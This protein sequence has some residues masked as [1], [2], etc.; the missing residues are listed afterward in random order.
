MTRLIIR[1]ALVLLVSGQA[2][3]AANRHVDIIN[4]TG[5]TLSEFYASN[6][7]ANDWEEDILGRQT[8]ANGETF[9]MNIDDG[10]GACRFDFRA[11]FENGGESIKRNVN[12]CQISTFTFTR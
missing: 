7:G 11:V 6:T 4:K 5:M 12:V 10:T 9:D 1:T 3:V 2:A 8:I